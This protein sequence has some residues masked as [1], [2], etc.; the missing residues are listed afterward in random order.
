M[1]MNW[2]RQWSNVDSMMFAFR[3]CFAVFMAWGLSLLMDSDTT[4][5]AMAT[6]AI[7]QITGSRGASVKKS[8]ARVLGTLVGGIYVLFIAS[9]TLIDSWLY[10]SFLIVGIVVSLG[11]ASYFH[12]RVSYMFA[13]V[14]ITLSLVGFPVAAEA[15]MTNLFDLVQV[16]CLG[17]TFGILMSMI[18]SMV[19]PYSDNKTELFSVKQ[20]TTSFL[21]N[22]FQSESAA[23][24]KIT[25]AFLSFVGKK[26]LVVDDEIYGSD[27]AKQ[28]KLQSRATFY[29]CINIGIQAIELKKLGNAIG[30]TPT[31]WSILETDSFETKIDDALISQW[32]LKQPQLITLF[33]EQVRLF[34]QRLAEFDQHHSVFEYGSNLHVDEIGNFTDGYVVINNMVR[35]SLALFTLSFVWIELQWESGMTAM[36][37]AGMMISAYAANPGAERAMNA[38]FYA[39]FIAGTFGFIVT[40]GVMPI[41]SPLLVFVASFIGVYLMA[42]WFWQSKSIF[43][44]VCMVSLFSWTNLVP[45]TSAPTYDFEQFLN[46]VVANMTALIVLWAVY[47]IVPPRKTA[48]VIRDRLRLLTKKLR[49]KDTTVL[50]TFNVNNLILTAYSYLIEDSDSKTI[51]KL[52]YVK[53]LLKILDTES[54]TADEQAL[55]ITSI[56]NDFSSFI[57]N[58]ELKNMMS[59]KFNT[60]ADEDYKWFTL[61]KQFNELYRELNKR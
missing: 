22:V 9:V 27:Q 44:I 24:T 48:V 4:G 45:T 60:V 6:A 55:L 12:R 35:A 33:T 50:S 1:L 61:C 36:I 32:N 5:T 58:A 7:I 47:E 10:N 54:V 31:L 46:T 20:Y 29:D 37:M 28:E 23:T 56:D 59:D 53:A 16:R 17:I 3:F 34:S 39:Q 40:F 57:S 21:R 52:L 2:A 26:W 13:V 43:K 18:A 14:G 41:G 49:T 30:V 38:N 19:I 15:D 11:I 42:Y 51:K 25:S 8:A